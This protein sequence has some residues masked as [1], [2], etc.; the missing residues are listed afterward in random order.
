MSREDF[1]YA[2]GIVDSD[3]NI[4][5]SK[6]N[7]KRM[8]NPSYS[9]HVHVTNTNPKMI[10]YFKETFGGCDSHWD[11]G[12]SKH[13]PML[14]WHLYGEASRQFLLQLLPFLRIKTEQARL[15]ILFQE[16]MNKN[17]TNG[18]SPP[19]SLAMRDKLY[20]ECASLNKRGRTSCHTA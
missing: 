1:I 19:E 7:R 15:S 20:K 3:G 12:N 16:E 8:V 2:A 18:K 6:C 14:G 13:K 5:I 10:K 11:D 4:C 17:G 9:T